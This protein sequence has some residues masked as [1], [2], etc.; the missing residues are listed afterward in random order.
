MDFEGIDGAGSSTHVHRLEERIE[1]LDKYQDV[2][3]THEPW[4]SGEIKRRLEE[5][6]DAYSGG[7][8]MAEL[9]I[10]DRVEHV[11][12]LVRPNLKAGVI[13]L[14]S[15][16]KMSTCAYQWTQGVQL[17]DLLEMHENRGL[18]TPDITFFLDIPREVA[19]ERIRTTRDRQEKFER[20]KE[21]IDRLIKSYGVLVEMS[22]VDPRPFGK[23]IRVNGDRPIDEVADEIYGH[24]LEVYNKRG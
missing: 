24:F 9:Y 20:N 10:G 12:R 15:R 1:L 6:H 17:H 3:R 23:V 2:L 7:K 16:Y 19:A 21:F 5:D 8:E 11:R 14:S 22:K 18:L 4:D 13:V